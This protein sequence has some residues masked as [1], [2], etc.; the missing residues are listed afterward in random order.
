MI[1]EYKKLVNDKKFKSWINKNKDSYLCS[2]FLLKDQE[3]SS[4]WQFDYYLPKKKRM[5]TFVVADEINVSKNQK[6]FTKST[7][8]D[9]INLKDVKFSFDNVV[10]LVMPKYKGKRFVKEIIIIQSLDSKLLWNVSLVT[11]DFNLI[12]LKI[13]AVDG[14]I[15]EETSS[16][17][18]QFKTS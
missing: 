2:V 15:L 7:S 3:K 1:K 8:I 11:T 9:Q 5:A 14:K 18:L 10:K 6:I 16:S 12:N 4:G 17:L 13:D